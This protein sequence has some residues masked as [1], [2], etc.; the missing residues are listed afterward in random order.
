MLS[1]CSI[2]LNTLFFINFNS[3]I[4]L[5]CLC[6]SQISMA[7]AVLPNRTIP[8]YSVDSLTEIRT[9]GGSENNLK[10]I[11]EFRPGT[12][13]LQIPAD[14]DNSVNRDYES[15][16]VILPAQCTIC[17]LRLRICMK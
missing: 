4:L 11:C 9:H 6:F 5:I 17:Q 14:E 12:S 3:G 10:F 7:A 1:C 15:V 2:I 16:S 8:P 13:P